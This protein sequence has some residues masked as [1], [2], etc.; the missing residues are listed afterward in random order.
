MISTLTTRLTAARSALQGFRRLSLAVHANDIEESFGITQKGG[1]TIY[2]PEIR[3]KGVQ[4]FIANDGPLQLDRPGNGGMRL[5]GYPDQEAAMADAVRLAEGMTRKHICYNTGF[6]GAKLVVHCS[7][8]VT[9]ATVDRDALMEDCANALEA[10]QG[11]VWTGCDLNTTGKDMDILVSKTPYVLAGIGSS[12]DTNVATAMTTIGSILGV[13]EANDLDIKTQTFLVQG[14]GKVGKHVASSLA[15]LGA[16]TVFTCDS[17][18]G[19]ADIDGCQPLAP[20]EN[21][22][23]KEVDFLVPCANSLAIDENVLKHMPA[24]SFVVGATNQ[25]YASQEVRNAFDKKGTLH[26]PESISSGG[27]IVADSVE[28]THP[29]LFRTIEPQLLYDWIIDISKAKSMDLCLRADNQAMNI[30]HVIDGVYE[31]SETVPVGL[32]F[33]E[34]LGEKGY[35]VPATAAAD[36][37][38]A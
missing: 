1:V 34:W 17:H 30:Q 12:V 5:L 23:D 36:A 27:A 15:S 37:T 3:Q 26:I 32:R 31:G 6:S 9:P 7:D 2:E 24:P 16:K 29:E 25:P 8:S 22:F 35:K 13:V 21:W 18:A 38:E 11:Q 4:L 14:C 28:W 10:L 20:E 19:L 33:P